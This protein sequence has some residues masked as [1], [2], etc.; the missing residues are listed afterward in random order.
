MSKIIQITSAEARY[1]NKVNGQREKHV[2]LFAL[3]DSGRIWTRYYDGEA[4]REWIQLATTGLP[5]ESTE[6]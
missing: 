6:S 4:Y 5:K 2:T 1:F 3:D